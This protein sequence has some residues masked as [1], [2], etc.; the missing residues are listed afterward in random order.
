MMRGLKVRRPLLAPV[1]DEEVGD[2]PDDDGT[3][4]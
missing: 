1:E 3:E 4:A 2:F